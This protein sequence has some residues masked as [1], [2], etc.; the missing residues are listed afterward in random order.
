[1]LGWT[2]HIA[3]MGRKQDGLIVERHSASTLKSFKIIFM[4]QLPWPVITW[5]ACKDTLTSQ[6]CFPHQHQHLSRG[7]KMLAHYS[8]PV[9][10]GRGTGKT[11]ENAL[12]RGKKEKK[13]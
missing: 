3:R 4:I 12:G 2:F 9:H 7:Y 5:V 11:G 6:R 13:N 1:M 10:N 8:L